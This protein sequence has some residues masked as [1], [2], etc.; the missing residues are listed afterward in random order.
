MYNVEK[1]L[2]KCLT[3]LTSQNY[4]DYEIILINDCSKDETLAI[5]QSWSRKCS[6]I[7]LIDKDYNTGLSDTRNLGIH[8]C[9]GTYIIFVDSDDYIEDNTLNIF[10][11]I[12]EKYE[13]DVIYAGYY[14]EYENGDMVPSYGF[15]SQPNLLYASKD[16]MISELN[17]RNL[18]ASAAFGIYKREMLQSH[19]L[20]FKVGILHEDEHWTPRVL[21]NANTVYLSDFHFYHYLKREGSITTQTDR[22]K[23]GLDLL[24]TCLELERYSRENISNPQLLKLF[25]N[26][27]A[28]LYM[29][30]VCIGK[31]YRK[32]YC[33]TVDRFFPIKHAV[34][35]YDRL[36]AILFAISLNVYAKVDSI[37]GDD[38]R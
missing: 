1:Y 26:Q 38:W 14:K 6:N 27:I 17:K 15:L 7:T 18:Y 12:I 25:H 34:K 23:N 30:A 28:K 19:D 36:K 11:T 8:I 21:I 31:L 22:T 3:S 16:F 37:L 2:D 29:K 5:A 10:N 20:F 32:D 4:E 35:G 33:N 24:Q 9:N 13:P